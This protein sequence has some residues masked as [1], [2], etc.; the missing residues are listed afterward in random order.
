ML[1]FVTLGE[2]A[3]RLEAR[4]REGAPYDTELARL[5]AVKSEAEGVLGARC[6]ALGGKA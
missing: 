4:R 5:Q 3:Q 6:D 1:G 2:A